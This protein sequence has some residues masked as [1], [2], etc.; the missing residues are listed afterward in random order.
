[1]WRMLWLV[2]VPTSL[3][4]LRVRVRCDHDTVVVA[5]DAW[6]VS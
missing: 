1:M 4:E 2:L 5:G 3:S 6:L